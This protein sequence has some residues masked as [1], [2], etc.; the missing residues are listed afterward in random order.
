M[1][2]EQLFEGLAVALFLS[3]SLRLGKTLHPG[4]RS[5]IAPY[6][7][8]CHQQHP[9]LWVANSPAQ[10]A[11]GKRPEKA[12][13]IRCS[14]RI[15]ERGSQENQASPAYQTGTE[16]LAPGLLGHIFNRPWKYFM[17]QTTAKRI[18]Q[19]RDPLLFTKKLTVSFYVAA[20][21]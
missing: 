15:L 13:Q 20:Y 19:L 17:V 16:S 3:R 1:C 11:S 12:D 9:P 6:G 21:W 14:K 2:V 10:P 5:L 7:Q 18:N 8:D 4:K